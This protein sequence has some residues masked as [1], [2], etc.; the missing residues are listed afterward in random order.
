MTT[1]HEY[2]QDNQVGFDSED[3]VTMP[4]WGEDS[5]VQFYVQPKT[6]TGIEYSFSPEDLNGIEPSAGIQMKFNLDFF[7]F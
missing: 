6:G 7:G 5:V 1:A 4:V 2:L 3:G